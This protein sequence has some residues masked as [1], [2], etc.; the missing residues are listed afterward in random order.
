MR[1]PKKLAHAALDECR[2]RD[3]REGIEPRDPHRD[4]FRDDRPLEADGSRKRPTGSER[5]PTTTAT[6]SPRVSTAPSVV[7]PE[8]FLPA[9]SLASSRLLD[10]VPVATRR[11][12]RASLAGA[13]PWHRD[14]LPADETAE[15]VAAPL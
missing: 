15:P 6:T 12:R 8:T 13:R 1:D 3:P 4:P 9:S 10:E 5:P 11:T 2:R 7:R 14:R